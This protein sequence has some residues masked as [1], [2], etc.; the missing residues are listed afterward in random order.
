VTDIIEAALHW[1]ARGWIPVRVGYRRKNPAAGEG[2][3]KLRP[4]APEIEL[5]GRSNGGVLL[6][7]ASGWLVDVD[8]DCA[9]AVALAPHYL[10]DTW[11]FGRAGNPRSHWTYVCEGA[12]YHAYHDAEGETV[13]ELRGES[14]TGSGHQS[15]FPPSVHES[16]EQIEWDPDYGDSAEG[17]RVIPYPDLS[18]RVANLARACIYMRST[19]GTIDQALEFV[20]NYK[21]QPRKEPKTT[22]R[23]ARPD[24]EISKA[25]AK[26]NADHSAHDY[27][28][29]H[30]TCPICGC[31]KCFGVERDRTTH[32]FCFNTDSHPV[33]KKHADGG[34]FG[35]LL[36]LAVHE[37]AKSRV[38]ILRADGY[39][40][41]I[42]GE[43]TRNSGK[44]CA[45]TELYSDGQCAYHSA[46]AK[47]RKAREGERRSA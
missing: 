16:G 23:P 25:A 30:G 36:D 14:S 27:P 41:P 7:K 4:T 3:Q 33:G 39:L 46:S 12:S 31:K 20:A 32:W 1:R 42:C 21:P 45:A 47:V 9:E 34:W 40:A 8:L 18:A 10:P 11:V 28:H 44:T 24:S 17:P 37:R 5:W 22:A 43:R 38:E 2:W 15:V 35:D 13:L 26:W 6:G 19:G 29:R